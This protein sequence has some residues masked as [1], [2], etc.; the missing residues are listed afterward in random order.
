MSNYTQK[1]CGKKSNMLK[2][3]CNV[4]FTTKERKFQDLEYSWHKVKSEYL[5]LRNRPPPKQQALDA[6]AWAVHNPQEPVTGR[7]SGTRSPQQTPVPAGPRVRDSARSH[8]EPGTEGTRQTQLRALFS[9]GREAPKISS[10]YGT[11]K[12]TWNVIQHNVYS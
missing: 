7:C 6:Q 4:F 10:I 5:F 2:V 1:L 3:N 12:I 8:G 11:K 9:A